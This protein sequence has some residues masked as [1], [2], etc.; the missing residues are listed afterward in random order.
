MEMTRPPAG[1]LI[2]PNR[3]V[4]DGQSGGGLDHRRPSPRPDRSAAV[5]TIAQRIVE[6]AEEIY[7]FGGAAE[8][9]G[10]HGE[11]DPVTVF[12]WAAPKGK[13]DVKRPLHEIRDDLV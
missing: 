8:E 6:I 10:I 3:G 13:P 5:T 7:D 11:R 4:P 1:G 12:T 9:R 2:E